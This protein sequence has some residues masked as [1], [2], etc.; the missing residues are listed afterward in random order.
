MVGSHMDKSLL[1]LEAKQLG[2]YKSNNL[3]ETV[4]MKG[5]RMGIF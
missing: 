5:L 2:F 1:G 3:Y 4:K